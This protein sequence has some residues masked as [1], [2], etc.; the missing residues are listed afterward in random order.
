LPPNLIELCCSENIKLGG[1]RHDL[2]PMTFEDL[3]D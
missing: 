3:E 2:E 1:L